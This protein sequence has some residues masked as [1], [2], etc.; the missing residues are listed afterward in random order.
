[1]TN[2]QSPL[3]EPDWL[4]KKRQLATLLQ[5][6]FPTVP[7]QEKW[8]PWQQ[9]ANH[10]SRGWLR[11][12]GTYVALP[13]AAAVQNYSELLQENL[14]E[15]AIRWQDNQLFAAHLAN[16]DGGQFVYVPDDCHLTAPVE[17]AGQGQLAN[18]HN[19][20]IVGAHSR[21]T[22]KE[23][24][25]VKSAQGMFAGTE[26]L[27]GTG[28]K[29]DYQQENDLR[30][31]AVYAA[32]HAYQAHGAHL[33]S[34]LVVNNAGDLTL[35]TSDFLDGAASTWTVK[36]SLDPGKTGRLHFHPLV[37]GF[38]QGSHADLTTRV[39]DLAAGQ[40][41]LTPFR[42]GSGEPLSLTSTVIKQSSG[43]GAP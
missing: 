11:H 6:R 3:A 36:V 38:G 39:N 16:I 25:M 23:H 17:I 42:T 32:V 37:D 28:A 41:E 13:L 15:K 19:L 43:V 34:T 22:I 1:M 21:V 27:L 24:L 12:T 8:L 10:Q 9:T 31:P 26:I 29:V 40:V 5:A 33:S 18:P 30:A 14:M 20:I 7:G 4:Q 2:K 35:S